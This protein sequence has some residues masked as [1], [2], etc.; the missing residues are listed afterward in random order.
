MVISAPR[1]VKS[2][3]ALVKA[4]AENGETLVIFMGLKKLET[5]VPVLQKHYD[6]DTP[7]AFVYN[8]G[9]T[10]KEKVIRTT[11]GELLTVGEKE[12]EQWLGLIYVGPCVE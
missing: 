7:A 3:E 4:L 12:K 9:Y 1:G 11:L 10:E 2:N 5:L 6:N 8:A